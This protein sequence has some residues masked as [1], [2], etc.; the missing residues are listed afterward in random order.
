[1]M[2]LKI[3]IVL[4]GIL[5]ILGVIAF[6]T[7]QE[8]RIKARINSSFGLNEDALLTAKANQVRDGL[9]QTPKPITSAAD[10]KPDSPAKPDELFSPMPKRSLPLN[11]VIDYVIA[12]AFEYPKQLSAFPSLSANKFI[13]MVGKDAHGLWEEIAPNSSKPYQQIN[14]GLQLVDANGVI[15]R[16]DLIDFNDQVEAFALSQQAQI[17]FPDVENKLDQAKRLAEFHEKVDGLIG[18][19]L[20]FESP[21]AATKLTEILLMHNLTLA[22]DGA[23]YAHNAQGEVGFS[24]IHSDNSPFIAAQL[25][26]QTVMAITFLLDVPR[27]KHGLV[28]FDRA[29][30]LAFSLIEGHH[31]NLVDDNGVLLTIERISRLRD[32]LTDLYDLMRDQRIEAGSTVALR[33]FS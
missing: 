18:L 2:D 8:R 21:L 11:E 13:A 23:F 7:W 5:C 1:M 29:V 17:R 6:N 27:I 32:H 9:Q 19:N 10:I 33:L 14:V 31:G 3:I 28:E 25:P 24:V 12:L 15:T 4:L 26:H 30:G 16:A 20:V 22:Q